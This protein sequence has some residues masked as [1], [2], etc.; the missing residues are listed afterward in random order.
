MFGVLCPQFSEAKNL[1]EWAKGLL[2]NIPEEASGPLAMPPVV[3]FPLILAE[4]RTKRP[5]FLNKLRFYIGGWDITNKHYWSVRTRCMI[6]V[7]LLYYFI[8]IHLV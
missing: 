4:E 7:L 3:K 1:G 8:H 6:V 2:N 5:D